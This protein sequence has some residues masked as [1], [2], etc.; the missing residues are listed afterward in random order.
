MAVL[1]NRS[2]MN[3]AKGALIPRGLCL[4]SRWRCA[5]CRKPVDG[6]TLMVRLKPTKS[7]QLVATCIENPVMDSLHC[8]CGGAVVMLDGEAQPC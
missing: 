6:L 5:R 3:R 2:P 7:L 1:D 8:P 4:V